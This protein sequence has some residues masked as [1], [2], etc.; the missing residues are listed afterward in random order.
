MNHP[1]QR[2]GRTLVLTVLALATL[3]PASASR[4]QTSAE[5]LILTTRLAVDLANQALTD[6]VTPVGGLLGRISPSGAYASDG[7]GFGYAALSVGAVGL[8]FEMT[9][10]DYQ[11]YKSNGFADTVEGPAAA[12]YA[13]LEL[14]LY[15]GVPWGKLRNVGSIDLLVRYGLTIGDQENLGD[16]DLDV[17]QVLETLEP[18]YGA[19]ARIGLLRGPGLPAVS[20]SLGFN[21]FVERSFGFEGEV[22]GTPFAIGLDLEQTSSF[23]LLEVS[24][25]LAFLTPYVGVGRVHHSM[26]SSYA[27]QIVVE[28]AL[29]VT[30][31]GDGVDVNTDHSN[32]FG[33]LE[34]FAGAP[35]RLNLEAGALDG[36]AYGNVSLRLV[37]L[38]RGDAEVR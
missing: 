32:F 34:L 18:I 36:D 24:K 1:H 9:S 11:F 35:V 37:P 38:G 6:A 2:L 17:G 28:G 33:G 26:T 13:D 8:Q 23:Y 19:G 31:I 3:L 20:V 15:R 30:T 5:E 10:P 4:A 16:S 7:H 25:R 14:G 27:A 29:G 21:H 22:D 12:I